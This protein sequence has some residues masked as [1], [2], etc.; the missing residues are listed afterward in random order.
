MKLSPLTQTDLHHVGTSVPTFSATQEEVL[1]FIL[2]TFSISDGT[3][4]LYKK[5]PPQQIH[6]E[7]ALW[8]ES[9]IRSA[10]KRSYEN[11]SAFYGMG[12][13]IVQR[14]VEPCAR[15]RR[16][17]GKRSGFSCRHHMHRVPVPGNNVVLN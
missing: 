11:K 8:R 13:T 1:S 4:T 3:K 9:F 10:G 5:N 6:L 7:T 15:S 2:A 17:E 14:V 12:H 16:R